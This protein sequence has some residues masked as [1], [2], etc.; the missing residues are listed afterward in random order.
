M[1]TKPK[2]HYEFG[3]F[4]VDPDQ[5]I[6]L[7]ENQPVPITP[8]AFETL[9]I[10]I[11]HSR[12]DL[13]K[14]EL[15][16]SLWPD[17]FV[18]ETTLSQNIFRLRKALGETHEGLQY[19]VTLPGRGYRFTALV[20]TITNDGEDLV[21]QSQSRSE[22]IVDSSTKI[23]AEL[24]P[25]TLTVETHTRRWTRALAIIAAA[26]VAIFT[27]ALFF[28]SPKRSV[29]REA[30]FVLLADFTNTTGEPVFNDLLRQGLTVQLEQSPYLNLVSD[31][32]IQQTLRLMGQPPNVSLAPALAEEVCVRAG[33][34]AV[35][36]GSISNLGSRYVLG[37]RARACSNGTLLDAEQSQAANKEQVLA[38]LGEIASKFRTRVG[39]SLATVNKY[40]TQLAEATTPSLEAL[41]AYSAG[42]KAFSASGHAT[43]A[44]LFKRAIE[45]DPQFAMGYASLARMFSGMEEP[46]LS[47]QNAAKAFE[48]RDRASERERFFITANYH[49]QV[50][51]NLASARQAC[52]AW[53]QVYPYDQRAHG[54]LGSL[55]YLPMGNYEQGVE[56]LK[57]SLELDPNFAIHYAVLVLGYQYMGRLYKAEQL[58]RDAEERKL[59]LP[60]FFVEKYDMAFLK[61][62][63]AAMERAVALS[64]GVPGAEDWVDDHQSFALAY[65]GHL[66]QAR[67]MSRRAVTLATATNQSVQGSERA[68]LFEIPYALREAFIG[69]PEEARRSAL[70]A[71]AQ[72]RERYVQFGAAFA[73]ALA[74]ESAKAEKIIQDLEKQLPEDTSVQFIHSPCLKALI[75]L[76]H[77]EP[78]RSLELLRV[79]LPYDFAVTR[80]AMHGNF[81]AM[82]PSYVR[83]EAYLALHQGPEAAAEFQKVLDHPGIVGNDLIGALAR[84]QLARSYAVAKNNVRAKAAYL[85]FLTL[86]NDADPEIP[87]LEQAKAEYAKL[88]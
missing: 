71:L 6:L 85:D 16:K 75:A 76:K 31:D 13:S 55:V 51:G 40:D 21:L 69:S 47:R 18:E 44:P 62:D 25:K 59:Q 9:L 30:D 17:T 20:R 10:L 84:L 1:A 26:L 7:R 82:Y 60:D 61:N 8:K 53:I 42:W 15:M 54:F 32:R 63:K 39:E 43:A 83:G 35:L 4:R 56:Q 58:L 67:Q 48:L 79:S 34:A 80:G 74:G 87:L 49:L 24:I 27:V 23:P 19:V 36:D 72:S 73:L 12:E 41:K 29:L 45:I 57:R 86:W 88:P 5:Q 22:L 64:R 28:R 3:P 77:G 78:T 2:V 66:K 11:R 33:A 14:D 70:A 38:A 50:T 52:E 65:S 81:G 46:A 68:A 37:L